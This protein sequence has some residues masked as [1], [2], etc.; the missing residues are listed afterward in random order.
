MLVRLLATTALSFGLSVSAS[1][2]GKQPWA[3]ITAGDLDLVHRTIVATHPGQVDD[4]NPNFRQWTEQGYREAAQKAAKASSFYDYK[5][6]L[7]YYT[8]GFHDLHVQ[9]RWN[10]DT[11]RLQWPGFLPVADGQ[12][13]R[14]S[15]SE[16]KDVPIGSIVRNCDG[17]PAWS[18]L[19]QRVL[20]Y[21]FNS[22]IP[23]LV[24]RS[25]PRLF[26]VET[27]DP[28][29][30]IA[31]CEIETG[32]QIKSVKLSWRQLSI[33]DSTRLQGE[34]LGWM[35]RPIGLRKMEGLW[36]VTPG[37]FRVNSANQIAAFNT[38]LADIAAHRDILRSEPIVLD[39]RGVPGGISSWGLKILEAI[40]DEPTLEYAAQGLR[41]VVDW[42]ASPAI[43]P[44]HEEVVKTLEEQGDESAAFYRQLV[45]DLRVAI[46]KGQ[47]YVR[48][49][50]PPTKPLEA[51]PNPVK[52]P[53]FLLTDGVCASACLD[54]VDL[55]IRLPDVK[56]IGLPTDADTLYLENRFFELPSGLARL[57][58]S[59]KVIRERARGNNEWYDPKVRWPGGVMTD[60]AV[61]KWI[62][63]LVKEPKAK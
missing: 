14:V 42:R 51:P 62:A 22:A 16:I 23:H 30:Q 4:Q 52:G 49:A 35:T 63:S 59:T 36:F 54:F 32:G 5:R 46:S 13:V 34:A 60:E 57:T 25:G 37:T 39:L 45:S 3:D 31:S 50:N 29:A 33:E 18:L 2:Q 41:Q 19:D 21:Y 53:V 9:M 6:V 11:V 27:A 8:N 43:I 56:H 28:S 61:A 1:A 58:S 47:P 48:V 40:W 15:L 10:V 38:F 12:K 17:K 44:L 55:A 26:I 24:E 20:P 7:L